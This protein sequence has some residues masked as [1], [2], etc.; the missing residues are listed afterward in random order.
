MDPRVREDDGVGRC[1]G[2]DLRSTMLSRIESGNARNAQSNA[3]GIRLANSPLLKMD[4]RVR[5][6]DGVGRCAG[7]CFE[8]VGPR[9]V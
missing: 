2:A 6:D 4:P 1:A 8:A 5:E 3:S 9:L 7:V